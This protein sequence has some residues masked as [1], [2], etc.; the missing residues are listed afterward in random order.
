MLIDNIRVIA[1]AYGTKKEERSLYVLVES[2]VS[3]FEQ[4]IVKVIKSSGHNRFSE[5]EMYTLLALNGVIKNSVPN[6]IR[7]SMFIEYINGIYT[8]K[9]SA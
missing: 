3:T 6:E 4:L 7:N 2:G 5:N 1:P 9:E 8:L